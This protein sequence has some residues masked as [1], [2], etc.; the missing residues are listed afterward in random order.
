MSE[1]AEIVKLGHAGDGIAADGLFVPY[2]VPGDVVRVSRE[3]ARGRLLEIVAPGPWRGAASCRHFGR[4]GGC[5]LQHVEQTAYLAW[6]RESVVTALK[7]RGFENPPVEDIRA[8]GSATR[9]RASFKVKRAGV[10][11]LLGFYEPESRNLVDLAECPILVPPLAKLMAKLRENLAA[12]LKPGDTA[13]LLATEADNGIDLSLKLK[14][15]RGPDILMTLGEMAARLN[16][17]RLSWNGEAVAVANAPELRVGK[18]RIALPPESFLQ[19]TRAGERILQDLVRSEIGG[20]SRMA[21]L[22][23]GCGTFT[24][25]LAETCAVH[26]A[27]G[28][29]AHI[30]ALDAAARSAGARVT[31]E[32]RDLFRRPFAP[33]ELSRFDA[34]VI[35][36]PRPGA[37]AQAS[38]LA[39]SGVPRILYVSCNPASFARDARLLCDGGYRLERVV[40]LDQFLWSPHVEIFA[41]FNRV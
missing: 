11:V 10:G 4:C 34:A 3:G 1:I 21:D 38:A 20:A 12:I 26:A 14:R 28:D 6:K 2:T 18:F 7:Q 36:P 27:D 39:R 23:S 37:Q 32:V 29:A 40:P 35:D 31:A 41:V 22:F 19:P 24:F 17:A 9:R 13:E 8:V 15:T 33:E 25:I 30:A 16:L 5:A